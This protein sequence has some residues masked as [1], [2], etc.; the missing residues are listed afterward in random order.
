MGAAPGYRLEK[1]AQVG[2]TAAVRGGGVERLLE[3]GVLRPAGVRGGGGRLRLR[4]EDCAYG[5]EAVQ[6]IPR[7]VQKAWL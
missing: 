4:E 5:Q 3:E 2:E 7:D 1:T 6:E